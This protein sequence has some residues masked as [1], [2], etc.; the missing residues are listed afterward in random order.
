MDPRR[1]IYW[2]LLA[3]PAVLYLLLLLVLQPEWDGGTATALAFLAGSYLMA[4]AGLHLLLP[5][6][7]SGVLQTALAS[8]GLTHLALQV[9][10]ASIWIFVPGLSYSWQLVGH[11]LLAAIFVF[12][13]LMMLSNNITVAET[14][15]KQAYDVQLLRTL[16]HRVA[17]LEATARDAELKSQMSSLRED[18]RYAPKSSLPGMEV[19][20]E[21]L[22]RSVDLLETFIRTDAR[23]PAVSDQIDSIASALRR[24]NQ[25]LKI[26]Q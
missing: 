13:F 24:R 22:Q 21:G 18:F 12:L 6:R 19:M 17:E 4:I 7:V 5:T 16:E 15:E 8:I 14:V 2:V 20:D 3:L 11:I 1:L 9:V 26:N 25:F 10:V 23:R